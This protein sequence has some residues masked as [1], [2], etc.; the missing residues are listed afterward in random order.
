MAGKYQFRKKAIVLLEDGTIFYGKAVGNSEGSSFGEICFN[1]GM[2]GYQETFTDPSYYGQILVTTNAHIGNYGSLAEEMESDRIQISGLVCKSFSYHYSRKQADQ[3]L[4]QFL[5]TQNLIAIADVDTRALV[6]YIREKGTM[7]AAISTEVDKIDE[8]KKKLAQVPSMDGLELSSK[9]STSEPYYF[10]D[11]NAKIKV[12]AIDFGIKKSI[13]SNL[14]NRG[15]YIK[16]FPHNASYEEVKAWNPD[17]YFLSNGPGDPQEARESLETA[18][19]LIGQDKPV[20]GICFGHQLMAMVNGGKTYKMDIGHRG[21]NHPV[22]NMITGKGEI[23]SQ[24]HGFAVE[25][26]SLK[27]N[28][29][30]E[31]TH[32]HLNDHTLAGFR[33]KDKPCF[34]VQYH[35]EAGAGPHD[36][37]YLFDQFIDSIKNQN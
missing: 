9:V 11:E 23:T 32:I 37:S 27:D 1:T 16:V 28:P 17:A 35:P 8:L 26:D 13:L 20:Y 14:A 2:T 29:N 6:T 30:V 7:N 4:E 3:S 36:A 31:I 18:R 33:V 10:G 12:S 22:K 5:E 15:C 34:S 25:M 21:I 19:Q 24:N